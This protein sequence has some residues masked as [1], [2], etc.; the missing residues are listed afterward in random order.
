MLLSF[1]GLSSK[2]NNYPNELSGGEQQ[3]IS[4]AHALYQ[5]RGIL[6]LD[7]PTSALDAETEAAI[8]DMLLRLKGK[9]TMVAVTHRLSTILQFD[10]VL[11]MRE[12]CIVE[13]GAPK[14]LMR[15][16]TYFRKMCRE[17]GLIQ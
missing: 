9:K 12:G 15:K 16:D 2:A 17:Q 3:R 4:M 14:E 7:E 8:R 10:C 6:L 11:V 5:N 1:V 13:R